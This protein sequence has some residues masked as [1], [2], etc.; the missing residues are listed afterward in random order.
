M[1]AIADN[2]V[3]PKCGGAWKWLS[4]NGVE[5]RECTN[6]SFQQNAK[7]G[8]TLNEKTF[9]KSILVLCPHCLGKLRVEFMPGC[10]TDCPYCRNEFDI[11]EYGDPSIIVNVNCPHCGVPNQ[12]Y[13]NQGEVAFNCGACNKPV[14]YYSG[15]RY[16][17]P[18]VQAAQPEVIE[19]QLAP[20]VEPDIIEHDMVVDSTLLKM[21]CAQQAQILGDDEMLR[22]FKEANVAY[23]DII[24]ESTEVLH[25]YYDMYNNEVFRSENG[26]NYKELYDRSVNSEFW[27]PKIAEE[28]QQ[29][30]YVNYDYTKAAMAC[31][32]VNY[33]SSVT[34]KFMP[35]QNRTNRLVLL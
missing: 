5:L 34:G 3:C 21:I 27:G 25:I 28:L 12:I 26:T 4:H 8:E 20:V 29:I 7:T 32:V 9:D 1:N 22:I 17:P 35:D 23:V 10:K 24:V 6:C 16:T 13:A 11:P 31:T 18:V 2:N 15:E 19:P 14:T 33:V 30:H